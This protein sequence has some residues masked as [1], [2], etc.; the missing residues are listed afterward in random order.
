MR[1]YR[2]A[3]AG[4]A[5]G[6]LL[7]VSAA[8]AATG[9]SSAGSATSSATLVTVS[10]GALLDAVEKTEASLGT[11]TMSA[12]TITP[13]APSVS[14]VPLTLNGVENGAVTVTPANSPKSVD[15]VSTGDLGVLQV[16]GPGA[17]MKASDGDARSA[18]FGSTS[19][20]SAKILGLPIALQGGV[21]AGSLTDAGQAKAAKSL[22]VKNV[23][24]PN[25]ADL[26]AALGLDMSK[27]PVDT[28]NALLTTLRVT[29]GDT[30][31][32]ALDNAN[33]AVETTG[34]ALQ[35]GKAEVAAATTDLAAKTAAFDSALSALT[36][37]P[38]EL[39]GPIDHT[40]WDSAPQL[41]RDALLELNP[42]LATA[43]G[44]YETAK[45]TLADQ[46]DDIPALLAAVDAATKMLAGIVEGVLDGLPL[47]EVGAIEVGTLA[48]VGTAKKADVVGTISGVEVLG[49]D[50][51]ADATGESTLDVATLAGDTAAAVN[52]AIATATATLTGTLN[53]VTGL[54][55]PA[56]KIE[57]LAKKTSTGSAGGYGIANASVTALS[58]S[59]PSA[60]IPDALALAGAGELPGIGEIADGFKTAPLSLKVGTLS[61]AAKFRAGSEAAT[62][63]NKP[64]K[65]GSEGTHPA[66][67]GPAGLAI[68]AVVGSAVA[69]GVRRRL[70]GSIT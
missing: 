41:V 28:L 13:N 37:L 14:F 22:S 3:L 6:A 61:E 67:G 4:I 65:P 39:A 64:A 8:Q 9:V 20:G 32:T 53:D 29:I 7:P 44:E 25:V 40:D 69:L 63:P 35:Q 59:I 57:L 30:V 16:T 58:I 17:A 54:A 12:Q 27:L 50:V 36:L 24:L 70:R 11:L 51:L 1:L 34:D 2:S 56:P 5:L 18:S 33:E 42:T 10:V 38:P 49:N 47:V 48:S 43:A 23:A 66:T 68:V 31:Q 15:A 19:L 21:T 52:A 62:P 26:L 46:A 55:I 45:A 60:T